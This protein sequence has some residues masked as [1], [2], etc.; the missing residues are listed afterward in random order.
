MRR[1]APRLGA[2][3]AASP[4]A[5]SLCTPGC[6]ERARRGAGVESDAGRKGQ[7]GP[8]G[9]RPRVAAAGRALSPKA[10]RGR[11]SLRTCT[12]AATVK[13]ASSA[14]QLPRTPG[15]WGLAEAPQKA[16]EPGSPRGHL[17]WASPSILP[18]RWNRPVRA[19]RLGVSK[20]DCWRCPVKKWKGDFSFTAE[21]LAVIGAFLGASRGLLL[22]PRQPPEPRLTVAASLERRSSLL[23]P[24]EG[25]H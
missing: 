8:G 25:F 16:G 14:A 15:P 10:A 21:G 17:A 2:G 22:C 11:A 4:G 12:P 6:G 19:A 1:G 7:L 9:L 5:A 3:F 13:G 20:P 18:L 23:D 24:E